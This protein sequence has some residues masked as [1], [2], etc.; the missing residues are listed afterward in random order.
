MTWYGAVLWILFLIVLT[1][2]ILVYFNIFLPWWYPFVM[3]LF[4][5]AYFVGLIFITIWF[6]NDSEG[7]RS[8]AVIG[9]WL[10]LGAAIGL[11]LFNTAFVLS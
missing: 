8:G 6:C 4:L 3:T 7:G 5:L 1:N 10:I 11:I 9:S 2:V